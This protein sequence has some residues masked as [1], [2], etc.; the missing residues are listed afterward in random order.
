[1]C[2]LICSVMSDSSQPLDWSPPDSFV[3]GIL[4][5]RILEQVAISSS[6]GVCWPRY[7][8]CISCVAHIAARFFTTEPLGKPNF[9]YKYSESKTNWV[10]LK[11]WQS[12][13]LPF[14][15][16]LNLQ[17]VEHPQ[18]SKADSAQHI[19]MPENPCICTSKVEWTGIRRRGGSGGQQRQFLWS[20]APIYGCWA[21]SLRESNCL[22]GSSAHKS[23][24][25]GIAMP[26]SIGN[27]AV[28]ATGS[29]MIS[30]SLGGAYNSEPHLPPNRCTRESGNSEHSRGTWKPSF[31]SMLSLSPWSR[32]LCAEGDPAIP[33][34]YVVNWQ[35]Q[36]I[37]DL[38]VTRWQFS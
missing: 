21:N 18:P 6:R 10:T 16:P 36:G 8:T 7:Q 13:S 19:R 34:T 4:Q 22:R 5:G 31:Q 15:I 35:Q 33:V 29:V 14:S 30:S 28:T 38:R 2:V 26:E 24:L 27:W 12:E 3:H 17:P 37:H 25:S 23:S 11:S 32:S 20:Q 9:R 1:M